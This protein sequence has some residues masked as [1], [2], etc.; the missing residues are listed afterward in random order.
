MMGRCSIPT[1]HWNSHAPQ[2]VH[3]KTA[4]CELYLPKK[5]FFRARADVVQVGPHAQDD[6]LG[7]EELSGVGGGAMFGAAPALHA[8]IGLQAD[9]LSKVLPGHQAEVFIAR[10]AAEYR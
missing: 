10:R 8:R 2:V 6:F 5:R 4:S 1:G 7:V 3:W 9:D